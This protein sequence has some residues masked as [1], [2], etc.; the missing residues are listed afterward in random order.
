MLPKSL[1][2]LK[3]ELLYFQC[4]WTIILNFANSL[5]EKSR[6]YNQNKL[7]KNAPYP[8]TKN[9]LQNY[10]NTTNFKAKESMKP[11]SCAA[12]VYSYFVQTYGFK[13]GEGTGGGNAIGATSDPSYGFNPFGLIPFNFSILPWWLWLALAGVV[14]Y[15]VQ[16]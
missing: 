10:Y 16:K 6:A 5:E 14:I 13:E 11:V 4:D 7:L 9:F 15:K 12:P 8:L 3:D 1:N 2:T